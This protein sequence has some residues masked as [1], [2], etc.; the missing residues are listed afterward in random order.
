MRKASTGMPEQGTQTERVTKLAAM[1]V[2]AGWLGAL[3]LIFA[4]PWND[5]REPH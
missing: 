5:S 2:Q 3:R 4:L 1:W